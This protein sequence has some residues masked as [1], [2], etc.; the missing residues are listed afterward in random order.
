MKKRGFGRG[1][2]NGVGGKIEVGET[3]PQAAIREAKEEVGVDIHE[4]DIEHVG[5]IAFSFDKKPDWGI[6]CTVFLTIVWEGEPTESEEMA[7]Q[8]FSLRDIPYERMWID[9]K[10]W[11]PHMLAGNLLQ[12][13]FLFNEEGSEVLTKKILTVGRQQKLIE[14]ANAK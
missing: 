6:L 13:S 5:T 12:A 8:W 11:L 3:I 4:D 1:K 9:D 7:P 10:H 2:F 14:Y